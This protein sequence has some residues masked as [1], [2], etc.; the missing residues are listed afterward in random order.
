MQMNSGNPEKVIQGLIATNQLDKV[1][2]YCQQQNYNPDWIS[3]LRQMVPVN[4]KAAADL[5]KM[6]TNRDQGPPK[7]NIEQVTQV[8]LEYNKI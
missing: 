5:A 3:I 1:G 8:F 6:I 7:A 2:P 4:P